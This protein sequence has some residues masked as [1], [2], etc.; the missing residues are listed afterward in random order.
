VLV[1]SIL[2]SSMAF[3]DGPVVNVALPALQSSL[4][5]TISQ[6]QWV[7]ESY[8]LCL[9]ALLLVGGALG[10]LYSRRKVFATGVGV[11]ALAS[12]WCGLSPNVDQLIVA[13]AVQGVG[14]ALLGIESLDDRRD[15]GH[16]I[17]ADEGVDLARH[18]DQHAILVVQGKA[19]EIVAHRQPPDMRAE[20]DSLYETADT[21][22][23][24][25]RGDGSSAMADVEIHARVH[26]Q[27]PA[28]P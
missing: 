15:L 12:A 10:D 22:T 17:E 4:H 24:A 23:Q 6:V 11:F 16:L 9:A 27:S 1:V 26:A 14:G 28:H 8:A 3:I 20:A 7:V 2:G 18:F 19:S 5:A 13:R 25:T 21:Q